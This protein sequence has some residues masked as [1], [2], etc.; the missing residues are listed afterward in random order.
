MSSTAPAFV[1]ALAASA[2]VTPLLAAVA[3]RLGWTDAPSARDARRKLQGRPV[4]PI[5]GVALLTGLGVLTALGGAPLGAGPGFLPGEP[6]VPAAALGLLFAFGVGWIDDLVAGGLRPGTKLAC[7]L[8]AVLPIASSAAQAAASH[9]ESG[10]LAGIAW[11]GAAVLALN[12]LNTFDNADGALTGLGLVAFGATSPLLC[13]PLLGFLPFNLDG[14]RR[15]PGRS[16]PAR[17]GPDR[18]GPDRRATPTA[19]LGDAGSH[20]LGLLVLLT[21]GAWPALF[22]P[23]IDLLRLSFVRWRRGSAPW[24]GD[25]RHLAHRLAAAGLG[26]G[27]VALVLALLA[28]PACFAGLDGAWEAWR[29]SGPALTALLFVLVVRRTPEPLEEQA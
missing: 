19:Y 26:R 6:S 15:V 1:V 10:L 20:L 8:L 23:A 29:W 12:A 28:A 7:Q 4:P 2:L 14:R 18:R 17:R 16:A 24:V 13:A 22:L 5:G 27:S 11:G 9:G 3:A 25:R 21:P